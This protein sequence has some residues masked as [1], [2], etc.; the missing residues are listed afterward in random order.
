MHK[1]R[2]TVQKRKSR[3]FL[4]TYTNFD[5]MGRTNL[6]AE[7]TKMHFDFPNTEKFKNE[8]VL[9]TARKSRIPSWKLLQT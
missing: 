1:F 7:R 8:L 3:G 5:A 4:V 9:K 2:F 6:R